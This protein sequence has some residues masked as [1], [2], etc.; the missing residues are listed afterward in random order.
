MSLAE[1][2]LIQRQTADVNTFLFISDILGRLVINAEGDPLGK[3]SDIKIRRAS[4]SRKW[5]A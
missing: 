1:S 2:S 5:S 4:L 3:L